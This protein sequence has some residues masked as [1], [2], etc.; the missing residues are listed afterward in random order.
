M[1]G[2]IIEL[3]ETERRLASYLARERYANNRS[4]NVKDVKHGPQSA[5]V[6]DLQG[7]GAE[8]AFAK[9][10]N[11]FPDTSIHV[12]SAGEDKGDVSANG[13]K[14]DVK[15]T[16]H[17]NGMLIAQ[18]SKKPGAVD[19]FALMVGEFPKFSY[20]GAARESELLQECRITKI[21][22]G[23]VYAMRQWELNEF[24]ELLEQ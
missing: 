10:V 12:R 6:T 8:I 21:G 7:V 14:I 9:M 15:A 24:S 3:N 19:F 5:E 22:K 16:V 4:S 17:E 18:L 13:K 11:A 23:E 2:T 20:R 1:I